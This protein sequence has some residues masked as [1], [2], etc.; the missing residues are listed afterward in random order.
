VAAKMTRPT[1]GNST[2]RSSAPRSALGRGLSAL[3]SQPVVSIAEIVGTKQSE[4]IRS[5]RALEDSAL[6]SA[7]GNSAQKDEQRTVLNFKRDINFDSITS[8][9]R[10]NLA[11]EMSG[12]DELSGSA[13]RADALLN[14]TQNKIDSQQIAQN[15]QL[16][17]EAKD[18]G[19]I[20]ERIQLLDIS[21][22]Q[23]NPAQPRKIFV[24]SEIREL[25]DSI[26]NM[27]VLQPIVV[28][29][30]KEQDGVFEIVAGERRFRASKMAGLPVIPAIIKELSDWESL[31][32]ALV[33]NVQRAEL[34]PVDEAQAYQKLMDQYSLSQ[35]AVAERIGKERATVANLVRI[36]KLHPEILKLVRDAKL[37]LGHAKALLAVK[38]TSAQLSLAKKSLEE[39]LSV[40]AVEALAS[41]AAV[42]DGQKRAALHGKE[43]SISGRLQSANQSFPDV[44]ERLR[45]ALGTKVLIRHSKSGSGRIEIEYFSEVE[46]ERLVEQISA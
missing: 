12:I 26:R 15:H 35:E 23:A 7:T 18:T 10:S 8:T 32:I 46:L 6:E 42:L 25:A 24:D 11:R 4:S 21:K 41:T 3:I 34:N 17:L 14:S 9:L 13:N 5:E 27:G 37:S 29:S 22:V 44:L 30:S 43:L 33:E 45:R 1:P 31:E 2:S 39:G 19:K 28:R 16:D 40:R 36:L 38:D 20:G